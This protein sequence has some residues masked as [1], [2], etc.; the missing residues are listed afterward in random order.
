[1]RAAAVTELA[2][3]TRSRAAW[4]VFCYATGFLVL[5]P[6][7][8]FRLGHRFDADLALGALP[9]TWN[10]AGYGLVAA[11]VLWV[12]FS[13]WWLS[14]RGR[15]LP[16]SHLPPHQL[17]ADGPYRVSRHP[18]YLGAVVALVGA[19]VV[20]RSVGLAVLVP[21]VFAWGCVAYVTGFEE[22][23]L[24]TRYGAAYDDYKRATPL[25][26]FP[27]HARPERL[28]RPA[29]DAARRPWQWLADRPV[30]FRVGPTIWVTYG[31]FVAA[32]IPPMV[33]VGG[34]ILID[35]GWSSSKASLVLAGYAV[36]MVIGARL[37]WLVLYAP[38]PPWRNPRVLR[39]V[40]FVSWG[41]YLALILFSFVV[42]PVT[43][44]SP[45]WLLDR[46]IPV[47]LLGSAI[48]RI[49]CVS[50]GCCYGR[51]MARG[52]CWRHPDS[53][54]V[55]ELGDA[56]AVPRTSTQ[57]LSSF[58]ALLVALTVF[59]LSHR[60]LP[61]GAATG[62]SMLLY[63]LG[64][65]AIEARRDPSNQA[66]NYGFPLPIGQILS[67]SVAAVG[68]LLLLVARGDPGWP[69]PVHVPSLAT[70]SALLPVATSLA[71]LVFVPASLHVRR[72]GRW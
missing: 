10:R 46:V 20:E 23:R 54:V 11:G 14:T 51:P 44:V 35:A 12:A 57:V 4:I 63:G 33:L 55:R 43:H 61:V 72:V 41:D 19:G 68:L 3:S 59:A 66:R 39:Q 50:Y 49:G 53:K 7:L 37:L 40:G 18:I 27:H 6:A 65:F 52:V 67:A 17:V 56:G 62:I 28:G 1:M 5:L 9:S 16:V 58:H 45:M 71:L 36:S 48:G 25:I 24:T 15:G 13:M 32:A 69:Q 60:P 2:V 31:L 26:R 47:G 38:A 8:L 30:L 34:Q 42:A 64:R 21:V 22:V 70:V 29:L